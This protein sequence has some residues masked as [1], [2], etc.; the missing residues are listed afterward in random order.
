MLI[1][2]P[3][4]AS[5]FDQIRFRVFLNAL[6]KSPRREP[7]V[8]DSFRNR[9]RNSDLPENTSKKSVHYHP[10]EMPEP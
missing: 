10:A 9:G 8:T 5:S 6:I 7:V 1:Q 4:A 2:L 3:G